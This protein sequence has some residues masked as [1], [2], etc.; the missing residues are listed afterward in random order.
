MRNQRTRNPHKPVPHMVRMAEQ[1]LRMEGT[2]I[3]PDRR[4]ALVLA[5]MDEFGVC[6]ET[7][8]QMIRNDPRRM[9]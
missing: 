2:P 7:A 9:G 1:A 4:T 5:Y 3:R 6:E 8:R